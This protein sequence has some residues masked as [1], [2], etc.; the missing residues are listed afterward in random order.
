M[1]S[2]VVSEQLFYILLYVGI[3][4]N[5]IVLSTYFIRRW[6]RKRQPPLTP[7]Q[8]LNKEFRRQYIEARNNFW[9]SQTEN[10]S[11]IIGNGSSLTL[12]HKGTRYPVLKAIPQVYHDLK[13]IAHIPLT[14]YIL[15]N[16][17]SISIDDILK[18]YMQHLNNLQVPDSI[19]LSERP[20]VER[21]ITNS[22]NFSQKNI[23]KTGPIDNDELTK[24][25]R[26]LT[27]D[28]KVL[29]N[30]AAIAQLNTMHKIVQDWITEY[31][32][33]VQDSSFKVLLIGART[34]R[35][36]NLQTVY[37]E[38]LLGVQRSRHIAYIEELFDNELKATSIFSTWFF[39]E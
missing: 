12:I 14:I 25:C 30:A 11:V 32:I 37:F 10:N 22:K 24:F 38:H 3:L 31:K 36:N 13:S 28:L 16:N 20:F 35:Q 23:N 15:K 33:D 1:F 26:N 21:I 5:C 4:A 29:L 39:D 8:E 2:Q 17:S 6:L 27:T 7:L 34:A 9:R 18:Q 19:D